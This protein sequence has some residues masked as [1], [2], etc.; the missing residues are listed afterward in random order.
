MRSGL[1]L[2]FGLI[3]SAS[4]A[5]AQEVRDLGTTMRGRI[6]RDAT[7]AFAAREAA[8]QAGV[9]CSVTNGILRGRDAGGATHYEVACADSP[10]FIV[11]GGPPYRAISCLALSANG[12][13]AR[14][15]ATC[16]LREN[17]DLRRHYARMA[18]SAGVACVVDAG[19]LAGLSPRGATI[20]E[21]GCAGPSGYWLEQSGT[22]WLVTECLT[23]SSQ[24][25]ECRLTSRQ[26]DRAAFRSRLAQT[27]LER[28][29]VAEVRAMGQSDEGSYFEVRCG[30]ARNIVVGFDPSGAFREVIPCADAALIGGGCQFLPSTGG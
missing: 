10:G 14:G 15:P 29:D 13:A 16:R 3:V 18:A 27:E 28:C 12:R 23:V 2:L 5:T 17:A 25:G 26:E 7:A 30:A 11:I 21:I 24:G 22:G 19:R 1:L 4:P 6:G 8:D 9:S 20:Y